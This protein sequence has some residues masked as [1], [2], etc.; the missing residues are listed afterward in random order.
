[1]SDDSFYRISHASLGGSI[2]VRGTKEFVS[3]HTKYLNEVA[4][5]WMLTYVDQ[6]ISC[7]RS[8]NEVIAE[9][10]RAIEGTKMVKIEE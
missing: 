9:V 7:G 6:Q 5:G 2:E 3:A 8:R 1:M 4:V 10:T